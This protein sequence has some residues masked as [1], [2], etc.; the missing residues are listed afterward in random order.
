MYVYHRSWSCDHSDWY[1]L[2]RVRR[3][4]LEWD[5]RKP[6]EFI[7]AYVQLR[8]IANRCRK[9][10]S[11]LLDRT[12]DKRKAIAQGTKGTHAW[13]NTDFVP[14]ANAG[15]TLDKIDEEDEGDG[16]RT[17][18]STKRLL[19]KKRSLMALDIY[20]EKLAE[21][22]G[23]ADDDDSHILKWTNEVGQ[24]GGEADGDD[25][26]GKVKDD[27]GSA[28][29]NNK[30]RLVIDKDDSGSVV[31]KDD[32]GS[33]MDMDNSGLLMDK[34]NSGFVI[35]KDDPG[36]V[37]DEDDLGFAM[38]NDNS[39]LA[40]DN[41]NPGLVADNE[42]ENDKSFES[43]ETPELGQAMQVNGTHGKPFI[44]Q[45]QVPSECLVSFLSNT[46]VPI[47]STSCI[48]KLTVTSI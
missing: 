12:K 41:G 4:R 22:V 35:D 7:K 43:D 38:D 8:D 36:F 14:G 9:D 18:S 13:R 48:L 27:S 23:E 2:Q 15:G 1:Y 30:R 34:D 29:D 44:L 26:A 5:I 39:G 21:E 3:T 20:N 11:D 17:N 10:F 40:A 28:M 32:S 33:M 45:M 47:G 25:K 37:V 19:L 42:N 24:K 16:G 6:D 31:D 46:F